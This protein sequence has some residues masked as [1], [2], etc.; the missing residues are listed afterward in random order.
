MQHQHKNFMPPKIGSKVKLVLS[1][2]LPDDINLKDCDFEVELRTTY[3]KKTY[4][5]DEL[6]PG[7]GDFYY[8]LVDTAEIGSGQYMCVLTVQ[9]PDADF[10]DGLR[11]EKIE[12]PSDLKVIP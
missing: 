12:F 6:L 11:T 1:C 2:E 3:K 9:V 4:K 7:D 8:I 10:T 5:K